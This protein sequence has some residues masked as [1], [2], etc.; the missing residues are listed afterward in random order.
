M[1]DCP[2]YYV[3]LVDAALDCVYVDFGVDVY[4]VVIDFER[5]NLQFDVRNVITVVV[6]VTDFH[7]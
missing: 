7:F 5:T 6:Y 1:E 2:E 3:A 4:E